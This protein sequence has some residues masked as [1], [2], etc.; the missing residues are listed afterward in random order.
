[1][2][3]LTRGWTGGTRL[4]GGLGALLAITV[5]FV[6]GLH[7]PA[8]A[9]DATG[10]VGKRII[11]QFGSVLKVGNA[12][13]D[14]QKSVANGRGGLR[15]TSRIYRVEQVSGPWL[16]LKAEK[17][18]A[19]GWIRANEII[20]YDN[21]IDYFTNQIRA[22][23][24][25][26]AA[27]TARGHIWKDK[28]EYDIAL[29]DY[30]ESVRLDPGSEIVWSNRGNVWLDKKEYDK[31]IADY[32]ES[33]RLDPKHASA[34]RSRGSVWHEKKDYDRAIADYS[35][36]IRIDPQ[37]AD[38]FVGRGQC[39]YA[40]LDYDSAI[41]DYREAIRVDP[42]SAIAYD[43]RGDV[44]YAKAEYDKAIDDY[45]EAIRV[46]Q[47][48]ALAYKDRGYA[49]AAKKDYDGAIV[50]YRKA[51]QLDPK[52]V[53]ALVS[54][55]F[56]R[57][58]R[59]DYDGAIADYAE[60]IRIDQK[61]SQAFTFRGNAWFAKKDYDRAIA[62]Y[63]E[64]ITLD[65]KYVWS[66]YY[67][68]LAWT[69][70]KDYDRAIAD[71][72]EALRVDPRF[73]SAYD[74]R[75][76]AWFAKS[77]FD[78]AIDD[79]T[80][81][82]R[83]D[84][85][86]ASALNDR[87]LAWER[88]QD[89]DKAIADFTDAIRLAPDWWSPY[90]NRAGAWRAKKEWD[91]AITDHSEVIRLNP[92]GSWAYLNLGVDEL[93]AGR[94]EPIKRFQAAIDLEKPK[95]GNAVFGAILGNLASR[96]AGNDREAASFLR[97]AK[98]ELLH[99]DWPFPV[100]A[101]LLGELDEA[102]LIAASPSNDKLTET[103]CYLAFD[104]VLKGRIE[105]A[106]PHYRWVKEHGNKSYIEYPIA[107]AELDRLE[108]S[109]IVSASPSPPPT[110]PTKPAAEPTAASTAK[111]LGTVLYVR[112]A[113][114]ETRFGTD[115]KPLADYVNTMKGRVD[116]IMAAAEPGT[117][118]GLLVGVG[119]KAGRRSKLWCQAVEG[120]IPAPLL[121]T[122]EREL[123]EIATVDLKV[124]PAGL[125]LKFGLNGSAP[126]KWPEVPERWNDAA[127]STRS[128]VLVPPDDLFKILWPD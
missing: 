123:G 41:A 6:F 11:L 109:T 77:E 114:I 107:L 80:E 122:I 97:I 45:T 53:G 69:A 105:E 43:N 17:E 124:S 34:Y 98:D 57:A 26:E 126:T 14:N 58:A 70:K 111:F 32:G 33:I 39:R 18:G 35:E 86:Y 56:A 91:K 100:V 40:K 25:N 128:K 59:E 50:D 87:G 54:C 92:K 103:H 28:K 116:A 99:R 46:D 108:G 2:R 5:C 104:L 75:G 24:S 3:S 42:K 64:A 10:W 82:I 13:V 96:R 20:L 62:D 72:T 67:R 79:Y 90:S 23:P 84:P 118:K 74:S 60:A 102:G 29:A 106:K 36:S 113:D 85:K 101:Y 22:N 9:Q 93:I 19:S 51:I 52:F 76:D 78:K 127:L 16:W 63:G 115:P 83:V 15:E 112:T 94:G 47:K 27:Y 7:P 8:S 89:H 61:S 48:F 110:E 1:M 88:K 31:A 65:P 120:E 95:G 44:W 71:H 66:I 119:I 30:N 21:A 81:A 117:A 38:G 68:G 125:G 55:G 49:R 121:R 37:N 4:S 73:V 12:V